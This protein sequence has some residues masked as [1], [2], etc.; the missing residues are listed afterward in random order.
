MQ[1]NFSSLCSRGRKSGFGR[2]ITPRLRPGESGTKRKKN[3]FTGFVPPDW[4]AVETAWTDSV[5]RQTPVQPGY[6][7]LI[8][9]ERRFATDF[10]QSNAQSRLQA[11]A[12]FCRQFVRRVKYPV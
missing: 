12:L 9:A 6:F 4:E 1:E 5:C 3:R 10:G 2:F 11:G 7:T 8:A